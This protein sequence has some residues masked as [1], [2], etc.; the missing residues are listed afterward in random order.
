MIVGVNEEYE[1]GRQPVGESQ[2]ERKI[3][4]PLESSHFKE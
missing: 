2:K 4:K 1:E 3:K